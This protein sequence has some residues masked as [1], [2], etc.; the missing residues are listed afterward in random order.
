MIVENFEIDAQTFFKV[1]KPP[2]H[3]IFEVS[4]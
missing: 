2:I 1:I 3:G 4:G